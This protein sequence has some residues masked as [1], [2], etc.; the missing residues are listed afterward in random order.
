MPT[1]CSV[2]RPQAPEWL[3]EFAAKGWTVIRE[4]IPKDKALAYAE[5]GYEWLESWDGLGF[6]RNDPSTRDAAH[7]SWSSRGGLYNRYGSVQAVAARRPEP[8][9]R[10]LRLR[11]GHPESFAQWAR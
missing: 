7:L 10:A 2:C 3:K 1:N 4:A 9:R 6:D 8:T 5:K 11:P